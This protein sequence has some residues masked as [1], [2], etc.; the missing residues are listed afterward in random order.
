[1]IRLINKNWLSAFV[2]ACV[3]LALAVDIQ[4]QTLNTVWERTSRTGAAEALP[5]WFTVGSVRG[6]AYGTV[7]G[8]DRVYAADRGNSTIQVMD[9]ATGADITPTTPFDLSGVT[10]GTLAINDIE[11]SDDGVIFLGNLASDTSPFRLYWWTQEG[12]AYADSVTIPVGGRVGDKFT[13]VGS[14]ADNTVEVWMA[15]ASVDPGIVYVATTSDQGATWSVE[16]ITLTGTNTVVG[17]SPDVAPLALGRTADFYVG[18]NSSAPARYSSVGAYIASSALAS[19]SRNGMQAFTY[20]SKDHLAVYTYRPDGA[21]SGN[22]T[23]QVLI[24]DIS[25]AAAPTIVGESPLMGDDVDTFSSIHGEAEVSLNN[26]GSFSVYALEGVNGVASFT[27]AIPPVIDDPSNLFFSEYIEGSGNNKALEIKNNTDSTVVLSNYQ[28]AQTSNGSGWSFFHTFAEGAEI[29]AGDTYVLITNEVDQALFLDADADEVLAFPSPIHFNGDDARGII[30]IDSQSGDTTLLDLF[31]ELNLDPGSGWDVAGVS[32][33][34]ANKTLWRKSTVSTGNTTPLGSF[35]TDA[36]TSE[37]IVKDQN[38]F[39]NLGLSTPESVVNVTFTVN[40][41]T[42]QDTITSNYDVSVNGYFKSNGN[43]TFE[44]GETTSWDASATAQLT[45]I[46]GDYWQGTFQMVQGDT[47]HYKYRYNLEGVT[48]RDEAGVTISNPDGNDL[49]FVIAESDVELDVEYFNTVSNATIAQTSPFVDKA[50]SIGVLFRVNV[51]AQV[52]DGTFDPETHSVSVRG[53]LAPLAWDATALEL[54]AETPSG[55][56]YFY[57]GVA[58]FDSTTIA[59]GTGEFDVRHKFFL[60]NGTGDSGYEST[61]DRDVIFGTLQDTTLQYKFFS[62]RP[63]TDAKLIDTQV[64]FEV[65]VGILE[66]LE[67][68]NSSFDTVYVRGQGKLPSTTMTYNDPLGVYELLNVDVTSAAVGASDKYKYYIRWANARDSVASDLYLPG[69]NASSSGWEEPGLTGGT[70]R[71]F[72]FIDAAEQPVVSHFYNGLEPEA[73]LT[74][75]NVEGGAIS[76][77]FSIDMSPATDAG[78]NTNTLFNPASD[79]VFLYVD[80]PFFALTNG[81]STAGDGGEFFITQTKQ[82]IERLLFTDDNDDMVYE[83]NLDLTLPTLNHIGFRVAYGEAL[84]ADGQLVANGGGFDAGRRY[85]QYI[86]PQVDAQGNVT[87]PSTF[88]FPELTWQQSNLP[89][90]TAPDYQTVGIEDPQGTVEGFRLNQN[91]PNPFNPS[92]AISFNLPNAAN[93]TLSVYNV[94]GQRVATLLNNRKYTSGSH[95]LNFD[96]SNLA[97]G[98]YIYRLEA[99]SFTSL[100]RMTLIK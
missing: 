12:G 57:S 89:F 44:G 25:D 14:V 78:T 53:S 55:D 28:I 31:G 29:A 6:I 95:T 100:K 27:N 84:S 18:G 38:D 49:R 75:D 45:N 40:M 48:G 34:T 13:V 9:A 87:W 98:V 59:D 63:P 54:T 61:P 73:R 65:N 35:G 79:S 70:D 66:G 86:Q 68:F 30:H 41:A 81:L 11:V 22:K 24:Y 72:T 62:N 23:G 92:T 64:G 96:A 69:I 46:G 2:G 93:V 10:G 39:S 76:I 51:G 21:S 80:T 74:A 77:T 8:N 52:Q 5:S 71:L 83:L 3:M 7:N 42:V 94:L 82:E 47:L 88:A 56:N 36:A 37:W 99:G 85:Y 97:S 15:T 19:A 1:M 60:N 91:Y 50:D 43:Q 33:A 26:D 20:E 32:G 90:E 4:A 17:S 67:L 16:E 58:Y